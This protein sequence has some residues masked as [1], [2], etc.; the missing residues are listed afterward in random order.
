MPIYKGLNGPVK[1]NVSVGA[2]SPEA[3]LI[4]EK[5]IVYK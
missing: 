1:E 4:L 2:T 5:F 3:F